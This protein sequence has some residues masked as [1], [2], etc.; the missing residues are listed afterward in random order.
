MRTGPSR[1]GARTERAGRFRARLAVILLALPFLV[2][3]P[4]FVPVT[5]HAA[6]TPEY[7]D[8]KTLPPREIRFDRTDVSYNLDGQPSSIHNVLRFSN[9]VYNVGPGRLELRAHVGPGTAPGTAYQRVFNTDGSFTDYNVGQL[10]FHAA[11]NHWHYDGWGEYQL[12]TKANYDAWIASGR[13]SS[14]KNFIPGAKATA[15]AEDEEFIVNVPGTKWPRTY[16][17]DG[18]Y[19]DSNGN[20]VE[21]LATGWG[22]TYDYYRPQQWFDLGQ[23]TL[24]NGTWVVRSVAD[25]NNQLYESAGKSSSSVEGDPSNESTTTF[26]VSGGAIQDTDPPTGT[27]A[28]NNVD[29]NTSS[30]NVTVQVIGRDDVSVVNQFRVSN[31]N[32]AWQTFNYTTTGSFATSISWN[33]NNATYGGNSSAGLKTVYVQFHDSSGKWGPSQ[34]DT[35]NLTTGTQ[36][37]PYAQA[38]LADGPAGYWRLDELAG[39]SAADATGGAQT[40]TYVNGP[41]LGVTGLLA[42]ESNDRAVTFNGSNNYMSVPTSGALSPTAAVSVEAWIK[43][44]GLPATGSF[45]SVVTKPE[46]YSLQFNG[47]RLEFTIMQNGVRQRLLAP[48]GAIVAGQTYQLVGTYDGTTQRLYINGAL[49]TSQALTGAVSTSANPLTVGSWGA[50]EVFQGTIDEPAV[51]A[52]T[53]SASRI[54]AHFTTGAGSQSGTPPTPTSLVATAQFDTIINLSWTDNATNETGYVVERDTSGTFT[55]PVTTSLGANAA[56]YSSTGLTAGTKYYYRVKAVN[57]AISSGYSNVAFATTSGGGAG[58]AAPTGLV[59]T[60]QSSSAVGLTWADNSIDESNFVVDRDT[61][62]SFSA[63]VTVSLSPG[64]TSYTSGGLSASTTYYYRVKA[65]NASGSSAYTNTASATTLATGP[66]GYAAAVMLDSPAGFWRLGEASGSTAAD[67]VGSNPGTYLNGI[68]L[69]APSLLA[70]DTANKAVTLDGINDSVSVPNSASLSPSTVT[71][72]A[73]IK[74]TAIPAAGGWASIVTKAEAYSLQFNG[75]QLEFTI[76]QNGVRQRLKAATGAIAVG[77][78]YFVAGTF[79]GTTQRLYINFAQVAS[80]PLSGAI[81]PSSNG[82]TIG[83]WGSGEYFKGSI[84]DVAV[85]GHLVSAARLTA[86]YSAG[87]G[88][89]SGLPPAAPSGLTA[90]A[91]SS[92]AINLAWTDNANNETGFVL[93]RA[94]TNAFASITTIPLGANVTGYADTGLAASTTYYYRIRSTNPQ[95]DSANSN[96]ASDTTSAPAA[97]A[98]PT[99]LVATP[100]S[101]TAIGLTWQDNASNET[102]YVVERASSAAFTSPVVTNLA[103]GVTSY[104]SS[105][106]TAA[107]TYY[108]RVKAVNGATSSAYSNTANATTNGAGTVPAAPSGLTATATSSSAITVAWTDNSSD[109]TGFV[110]ERAPTNAFASI[111]TIPLGAN[112]TSYANTGLAASTTYYYRV[113]ATNATGPSA[114]SNVDSATTQAAAAAAYQATVV[115]DNPVS[116]WRLGETTATAV[117]VRG[118]NNGTYLNSPTRGVASL[119]AGDTA[120]TAVSFDGVNDSVSVAN[121]ASLGLTSTISLEAWIKPAALPAAGSWASIITK[122]ESYSL[123]FNGP[124]L[125]FTIIQAGVRKRLQA[126]S[127]A[128]AVGGTYHV[129]GTYDGTTQRLYIDGSLA[130]SAALTGAISSTT[131]I[132]TIGSWG[133]GEYFRGTLDEAAVYGSVLSASRV[134]AHYNAGT[135]LALA[136]DATLASFSGSTSIQPAV[137]YVASP[138]AAA[139]R[140]NIHALTSNLLGPRPAVVSHDPDGPVAAAQASVASAPAS[141]SRSAVAAVSRQGSLPVA[142]DCG[143]AWGPRR[144]EESAL[145]IKREETA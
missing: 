130:V 142:L 11:H 73:W 75:P 104:T 66:T 19:P 90:T 20:M 64:T 34:T 113:R 26:V 7:P 108:Y 14:L 137:A 133:S 16:N 140:C 91:A 139:F 97:P 134:S 2:G 12:W 131:N 78:T 37:S 40:G 41:A 87:T 15:C 55:A 136:G 69:G 35:I 125:E 61:S 63:P 48:V 121:S 22:D 30:P 101:T 39:T 18:C 100:Q 25:P 56:S 93:E 106:L 74:P 58:P 76:I 60:A 107:T 128:I 43:P 70:G 99:T 103:A 21:G 53:L 124:R 31:N 86:H 59:A 126:A 54:L 95:G 143:L 77:Q 65:T 67:Q 3:G 46:A 9:T 102:G 98:A 109:E 120:N 5:V 8:I 72:E 110:L 138:F 68:A 28:I 119:L 88:S 81:G 115:A 83:S 112:V 50:S 29:V 24:A 135:T 123:Q 84:D 145:P 45:V 129:V 4:L 1:G 82:V 33:L 105:G 117:D 118:A 89:G 127:G 47:S 57:G 13:S 116:F 122:A 80:Q 144:S 36:S 71:V 6:G 44:S 94:P 96:T 23:G 42:A 62:P 92:S 85:F 79:D 111:T 132:L 32:A 27:V 49:S 10:Y 141:G 38:V 51:Y 52:T 114:N 17:A